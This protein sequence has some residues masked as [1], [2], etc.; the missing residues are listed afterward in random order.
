VSLPEVREAPSQVDH[1][2]SGQYTCYHMIHTLPSSSGSSRHWPTRVVTVLPRLFRVAVLC[3][4]VPLL[5]AP[6]LLAQKP[7]DVEVV[8]IE[9]TRFAG[10]AGFTGSIKVTKD[11]PI[12]GL[13]MS[14]EF[15]DA[16]GVLLTIL[17]QD[18]EDGEVAAG[19][20]IEFDL[21]TR[22]VPRAVSFLIVMDDSRGERL[23]VAGAGPHPF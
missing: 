2:N 6:V 5:A 11:K 20:K 15:L 7:S 23:L 8:Q 13:L 10:K 16:Q 14:L 3:L 17:K 18:I 22:D 21:G 19:D 4:T 9:T 1:E 12:K